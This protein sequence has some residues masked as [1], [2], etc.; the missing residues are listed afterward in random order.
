MGRAVSV[1]EAII[2]VAITSVDVVL[3]SGQRPVVLPVKLYA[4][5]IP[6]DRFLLME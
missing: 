5:E 3:H 2:S 4:S 6:G 1:G